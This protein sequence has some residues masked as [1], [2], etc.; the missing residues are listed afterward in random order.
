LERIEKL[1][2]HSLG[3]GDAV[4]GR[5]QIIRIRGG[6]DGVGLLRATIGTL[7]IACE[8]DETEGEFEDRAVSLA[9][10]T[11]AAF[12]VIGGMPPRPRGI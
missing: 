6:L 12:V 11:G 4:A 2:S 3:L 8:L 7:E 1:L 5:P 10:E 9:A